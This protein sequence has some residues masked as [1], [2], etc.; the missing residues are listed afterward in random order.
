[1]NK[2]IG[3]M[4][5][6][7]QELQKRQT[8]IIIGAVIVLVILSLFLFIG[9]TK[10]GVNDSTNKTVPDNT[11]KTL[12]NTPKA[13]TNTSS[14]TVIQKNQS[15]SS[16]T[17]AVGQTLPLKK[18]TDKDQDGFCEETSNL[19]ASTAGGDCND[20]NFAINPGAQETCDGVDNNCNGNVDE[21]P[22]C[23]PEDCGNGIDDDN[24][25]KVDCFDSECGCPSGKSCI[26]AVCSV[27]KLPG[28]CTLDNECNATSKCL[29]GN[30][31]ECV[32]GILLGQ[33]SDSAKYFCPF[34]NGWYDCDPAS[35]GSIVST[36][37]NITYQCDGIIWNFQP[38][39]PCVSSLDCVNYGEKCV[40]NK[41]ILCDSSNIGSLTITNKFLCDSAFWKP[42]HIN[43]SAGIA[44][45][46]TSVTVSNTQYSCNTGVGWS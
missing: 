24:D 15:T 12:I 23:K 7:I 5:K 16:Q 41:C 17:P 32:P 43:S 40:S 9:F 42:C 36:Y 28:S 2:K 19:P 44:N 6:K 14:T 1:M 30:C 4:K 22:Q 34:G 3:Q 35:S 29:K 46:G 11:S 10:F 37:N 25:G 39:S 8:E 31:K 20:N 38:L 45:N 13:S 26:N 27:A 18:C 33:I 21:E